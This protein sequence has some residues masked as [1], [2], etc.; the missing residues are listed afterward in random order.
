MAVEYI[1]KQDVLD[2]L[3]LINVCGWIE[4]DGDKVLSDISAMETKKI[5]CC[6][7]CEF[8]EKVSDLKVPN[9]YYCHQNCV[10][11]VGGFYCANGREKE[12]KENKS[13]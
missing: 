12:E 9:L 6:N 1:K 4:T 7:E 2:Y 10:H 13:K 3:D 11:R 5:V 8:G